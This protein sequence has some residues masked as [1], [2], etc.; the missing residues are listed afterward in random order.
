MAASSAARW[1]QCPSLQ[2]V[3]QAQAGARPAIDIQ[4]LT[5]SLCKTLR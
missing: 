2:F 5:I 3:I 1:S 4:A